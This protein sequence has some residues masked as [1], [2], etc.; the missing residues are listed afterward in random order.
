[1]R[2]AQVVIVNYYAD[3]GKRWL[4]AAQDDNINICILSLFSFALGIALSRPSSPG[5]AR[6]DSILAFI[7]LIMQRIPVQ[8][9]LLPTKVAA[10]NR[11]YHVKPHRTETTES[12]PPAQFARVGYLGN[13]GAGTHA[14]ALT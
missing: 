6:F 8:L 10:A 7:N 2:A 9:N 4:R 12:T 11:N 13:M 1:M 5:P 14:H 3:S